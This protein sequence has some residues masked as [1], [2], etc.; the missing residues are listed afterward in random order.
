[1]RNSGDYSNLGR[2]WRSRS[3][4]QVA[5]V[6][7]GGLIGAF[8]VTFPFWTGN[9]WLRIATSAFML[10]V[11]ALAFA[12]MTGFTG[13]P[14][15]G[16]LGFFGLGAYTVAVLLQKGV[17][18]PLGLLA[19]GIVAVVVC[20]IIGTAILRLRGHYFAIA[21]LGFT[22][23]TREIITNLRSITHGA[24]GIVLRIPGLQ[25]RPWAFAATWYYW[26]LA[27]LVACLSTVW[28]ISRSRFG[29]ALRS[30]KT[31]ELE[32]A[33]FGINTTR[34]KVAAWVI[35]SF[36]AGLAGAVWALWLGCI[37]PVSAFERGISVKFSIMANFGGV[38]TVFGPLLG[39]L[40]LET[41][42][43]LVWGA[44]LKWYL[45]VLGALIIL[46]ILFVPGGLMELL[47]DW[48]CR[49]RARDTARKQASD[50]KG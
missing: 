47:G 49:R 3:Y 4:G 16:N 10:A 13:Y 8:L 19:G 15:F 44:L 37:D 33:T 26:I 17:W 32:S 42:I 9:Y 28:W 27:I 14:A 31:A 1:M 6:V 50:G 43:Q 41:L 22:V 45:G 7:S 30:I 25:G 20:A 35:S 11:L 24:Q 18:Y 29:Y 46:I 38:G 21:G 34:Y 5:L 36:Y 48:V 39:A 2:F 40:I 12:I 23:A